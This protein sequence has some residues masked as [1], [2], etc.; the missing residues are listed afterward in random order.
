VHR[1]L[2]LCD[3]GDEASLV[4][5]AEAAA[6]EVERPDLARETAELAAACWRSAPVR[7]AARAAA[8]RPDDVYR[9]VPVGARIDG[10]VLSGAIDLLYRGEHGW[11][12]VDF[13]T[14]RAA[15]PGV[16]LARYR[17]QGAA[18]AVAAEAL[19]GAGS[20]QSVCFVAARAVQPDGAA[21]VVT[22]SVDEEVRAEA[23]RE[24]AAA[25][26]AGRALLPDELGADGSFAAPA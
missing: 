26:A 4:R 1:T 8:S 25:A 9:E 6:T 16:L 20:V 22:V 19:L 18:Y 23:R 15:E 17:P 3:L 21:H 12:V 10:V 14:D 13:K 24:I 5:A 2:E 7:A 11:V